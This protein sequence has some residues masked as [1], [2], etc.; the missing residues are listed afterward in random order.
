[1]GRPGLSRGGS[2][3][4]LRPGLIAAWMVIVAAAAAPARGDEAPTFE[5]D[6]KPLFAKR[7]TVC[8]DAKKLSDPD[9]SGGLA[10]G[11]FEAA[12]AGTKD[13][14]VIMPGKSAE[15]ELVRR[16]SSMDED[17]R[18][19]LYEKPLPETQRELVRRWID[20][21]APRGVA[22]ASP[23][24]AGSSGKRPAR[25][26]V[27]SLDVVLPTQATVPSG[28]EG[29]DPGGAV[30][31][32]L[33][34]GPLP[35]VS[36]L[37]FRGDGRHLAVGTHGEVVVW[38]LPEARPAIILH[39]I[40]G[41]VHAL[42]FSRDGKR[43]A[44]G[45]GLPART[46][47]VRVYAVPD[48]T[49]IH[50]FEGH[51]D[52]VFGLAFRPDGGQ[53][54]SA[55]FDQTVRLWDLD[56]GKPAGVFQGHS[57]FVYDVSYT[58]DG[59][60]LLSVSKDRSIKRVDLATLK[61]QRTYS[62]HNEDVLALAVQPGGARFVTAGNEPQLRWWPLDAEKPAMRNG[63]HGGPVHQ[64]A[65]SGDGKR[66]ISAGGDSSVRIWDG[67]S[68]IFLRT[69]PGPSE[70]QYAAALSADGRLAAAGGW[71][72]LV[73]VWDAEKGQ[74][75]ATLLQPPGPDPSK[76]EWLAIA[77]SGHLAASPDLLALVR[78]RVGGTEVAPAR[79]RTLFVKPEDVAR[80]LSSGA[81]P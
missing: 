67:T 57:D 33:K 60:S 74:L 42:A 40:P 76:P 51:G 18:M 62:D 63:G 13:R 70:W 19:P 8:H 56:A 78:W 27:R 53:L 15:S 22:M 30:Q 3:G 46:G 37:A 72:G 61:E 68:G 77:P 20:A 71:D 64:L 25:R 1:M 66:L 35:A 10:L 44:V 6:I 55:S 38:D 36:A 12:M 39:D 31:V 5:R 26:I 48:G 43:L 79:A 81:S 16:L 54:A 45:A 4:R 59:R 9:V 75:L 69:L 80:S 29:I 58:T 11:T 24:L 73:R 17:E 34:V 28:A 50:D 52:V 14:K 21:G 47:V 7:C 2:T 32:V 41:P 23:S 49:L 65:F